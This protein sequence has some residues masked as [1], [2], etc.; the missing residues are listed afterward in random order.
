MNK[1]KEIEIIKLAMFNFLA[2]QEET[3]KV[4]QEAGKDVPGLVGWRADVADVYSKVCEEYWGLKRQEEERLANTKRIVVQKNFTVLSH[5][6]EECTLHYIDFNNTDAR[7][8]QVGTVNIT[9]KGDHRYRRVDIPI[10]GNGCTDVQYKQDFA[11]CFVCLPSVGDKGRKAEP[12][13]IYLDDFIDGLV[14]EDELGI[15]FGY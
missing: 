9:I 2:H 8:E 4:L 10:H 7:K 13:T 12:L 11:N 5:S 1:L 3:L 15:K 6:S 14:T